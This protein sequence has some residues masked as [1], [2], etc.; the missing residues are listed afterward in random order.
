M[1]G[2]HVG[3]NAHP[4]RRCDELVRRAL[5]VRRV[6][7]PLIWSGGPAV[8]RREVG[9]NR[10]GPLLDTLK[11]ARRAAEVQDVLRNARDGRRL[12]QREQPNG[13]PRGAV[14]NA[15]VRGRGLSAG[16]GG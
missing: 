12:K 8:K 10:R 3:R 5:F 4:S 9:V 15:R 1:F 13:R 7:P 16:V 6:V 2:N 14:L 11:F